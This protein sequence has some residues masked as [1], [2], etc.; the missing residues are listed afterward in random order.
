MDGAAER[1]VR[2]GV[3]NG[4]VGGAGALVGDPNP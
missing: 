1:V 3:D 2:A 4:G